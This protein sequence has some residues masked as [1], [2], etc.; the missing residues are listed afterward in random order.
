MLILSVKTNVQETILAGARLYNV[1][2]RHQPTRAAV[3]HKLLY[4]SPLSEKRAAPSCR[5]TPTPTVISTG[6]GWAEAFIPTCNEDSPR[7]GIAS[8]HRTCI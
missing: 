2:K 6:K 1:F 7:K 5:A 8:E 4:E 3:M